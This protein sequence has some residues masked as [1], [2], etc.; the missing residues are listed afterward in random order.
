MCTFHSLMFYPSLS[1]LYPYLNVLNLFLHYNF[2]TLLDI[3]LPSFI[4]SY[5]SRRSYTPW[6]NHSP[7]IDLILLFVIAKQINLVLRSKFNLFLVLMHE[8]VWKQVSAKSYH[9]VLVRYCVFLDTPCTTGDTFY[10]LSNFFSVKVIPLIFPPRLFC[11]YPIVQYK[12][13]GASFQNWGLYVQERL[14]AYFSLCLCFENPTTHNNLHQTGTEDQTNTISNSQ[15]MIEVSMNP[16][17]DQETGFYQNIS[18]CPDE[19]SMF[20]RHTLYNVNTKVWYNGWSLKSKYG[21][22]R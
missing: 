2:F 8:G 9:S 21:W 15:R 13:S 22:W 4:F 3:I 6:F 16:I 12:C 20:V 17:K 5:T 14:V 7:N 11:M 18:P 1:F 19:I 10:V